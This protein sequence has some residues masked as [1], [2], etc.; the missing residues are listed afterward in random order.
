[1]QLLKTFYSKFITAYA[2]GCIIAFPTNVFLIY[3]THFMSMYRLFY[4]VFLL[5]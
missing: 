4:L 3:L 2:Y 1:M 5:S